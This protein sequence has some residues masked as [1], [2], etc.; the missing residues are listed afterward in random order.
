M[1]W[2]KTE[3]SATGVEITRSQRSDER[4]V[5]RF[6]DFVMGNLQLLKQFENLPLRWGAE[7][8]QACVLANAT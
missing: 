1:D 8:V 6:Y 2:E 3:P 5:A 4:S 7:M